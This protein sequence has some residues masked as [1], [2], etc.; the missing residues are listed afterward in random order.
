MWRLRRCAFAG[1]LRFSLPAPYVHA[2]A[3]PPAY[4][5]A[6]LPRP[7]SETSAAFTLFRPLSGVLTF[8][9]V[10]AAAG[11]ALNAYGGRRR[12]RWEHC[13]L[14]PPLDAYCTC[15]VGVHP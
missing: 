11:T 6:C 2:R 1:T 8:L 5:P 10:L 7:R 14:V 4:P 13:R 12:L 15:L 9:I 3:V